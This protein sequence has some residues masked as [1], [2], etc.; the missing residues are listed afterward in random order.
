VLD[1]FLENENFRRAI[2]EFDQESFKTYDHRIQNDIQL[3]MKNLIDK[4]GYTRQGAK[5]ICMYVIDNDLAKA[6]A[7]RS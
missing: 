7:V 4:F 1:P 3:L 6:F 2:R 5:E